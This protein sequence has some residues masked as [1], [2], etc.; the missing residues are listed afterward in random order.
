MKTNK[1]S[2]KSAM[3]RRLSFLDDVPSC[4][5]AVQCRIAQEEEPVMKK[6]V[7]V[8]RPLQP[9]KRAHQQRKSCMSERDKQHRMLLRAERM[10]EE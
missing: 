10:R 3:D 2:L 5:A 1:D 6:K 4:R 9:R 7:S 8:V